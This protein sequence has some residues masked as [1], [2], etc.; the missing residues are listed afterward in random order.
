MPRTHAF[1]VAALLTV[2]AP[3]LAAPYDGDPIP[4]LV[5]GG[6]NNHDWEWTTPSL[7]SILEESGRFEVEVTQQP[8]HTLASV[9]H[10]RTKEVILLDYNGPRWGEPAERA[11]LQA[12]SGGVCR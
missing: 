3:P 11:F 7:A 2:A 8:A 1:F 6:A 9:E 10:L 5:V 4:V 12:V